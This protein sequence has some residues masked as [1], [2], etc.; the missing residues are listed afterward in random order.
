MVAACAVTGG[1]A[2]FAMTYAA[3]PAYRA[4]ATIYA[5]SGRGS[6]VSAALRDL[7]LGGA[8]GEFASQGATSETAS[9]LVAALRSRALAAKVC[10][11]LGLAHDPRFVRTQPRTPQALAERLRQ[12]VTAKGDF[13]GLITIRATAGDPRLACDIANAY[14][15]ALDEFICAA[16]GGKRRFIERQLDGLRR[17]LASLE[18]DLEA[19]QSRHQSYDLDVEA[20]E[21]I[22]NWARL[23]AETQAAQVALREN[24]GVIEVSGS[25]DDLVALRS[26]RAGLEARSSELSQLERELGRRL[27]AL[28]AIGLD[29]ARLQRRVAAKQALTEMLESQLEMAR[30]AEV[31]EQ[32]RYQVI[33]RAYP[34]ERPVWPRRKLSAAAGV[35]AGLALGLLWAYA[36]GMRREVTDAG[37]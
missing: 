9:Y 6:A 23:S 26:R 10:T 4:E 24:A 7:N 20:K 27:A 29:M 28:P 36:L 5:L 16:A 25:I 18:R 15:V 34:A 31:E 22:Q 33:D 37:S 1:L 30:I 12:S 11:R 13:A 32:A 2:A 8:V 35:A 3:R 14:L 19:Y 21:L 17:Q